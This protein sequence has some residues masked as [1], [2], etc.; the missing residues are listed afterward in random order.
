MKK[1]TIG[2]LLFFSLISIVSAQDTR[3]VVL[4][5]VTGTW[6]GY[7][8]CGHE[9]I[10]NDILEDYP[11]TIIL[12]YHGGRNDPLQ[13]F[14]GNA[15][16]GLMGFVSYPSGIIDRTSSPQSRGVWYS[17]VMNQQNVA[18]AV[19]IETQR[20]YNETTRN[21]YTVVKVTAL[22]DLNGSYSV[23]LVLTED[24]LV[25]TQTSYSGCPAAGAGY[26]HNHVVR[27]ML[28]GERGETFSSGSWAT[29]SAKSYEFATTIDEEFIDENC[30]L[31]VM[32]YKENSN[33]PYANIQQAEEYDLLG[34]EDFNVVVNEG[35]NLVSVP[36][37]LSDMAVTSVFP[38][39]TSSAYE[40]SN[41]YY[42]VNNF[43]KGKGYWLKFG[44]LGTH[45]M[46]GTGFTGSV[47][48]NEGWNLI[49]VYDKSVDADQ[50]TTEPAGIIS[51]VFYGF[52]N[53]YDVAENL[54]TGKGYWVKASQNGSLSFD[55]NAA[56]SS[57]AKFYESLPG[58]L[59]K[60]ANNKTQ[61]LYF[62]VSS[63]D[64]AKADMPPLPPQ[65]L[66]DVRFSSDKFVEEANIVAG[67]ELQ[68]VSFPVTLIT[69]GIDLT[70]TDNSGN[71]YTLERNTEV[72]ISKE[73]TSF[74]VNTMLTPESFVLHQNYPNPFNP[75]T[76]ISFELPFQANIELAVYNTLGEKI[77][78]LADGS[79][80]SGSHE[81]TF[82][83]SDVA[84]G[85]YF[86]KLS[87]DGFVK[88]NKMILLK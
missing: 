18:P 38:N 39:A 67:I 34:G 22:E 37:E 79:Y 33:L 4:E 46:S 88:T 13:Y 25:A 81:V 83:A 43:E 66:F 11:K 10:Q 68:G 86:Y 28:N 5:Y 69:S 24:D 49:G 32:V 84:S 47:T 6:C 56:K 3:N 1:V 70:L 85:I 73:S 27:S 19:R 54:K 14:Y 20:S 41:G 57:D 44:E 51:S 42:T 17:R 12:G 30:H 65:G 61:K 59:V 9:I 45:N 62:S 15:I 71:N 50:V 31:V 55:A 48:L 74:T 87:S 21:L 36:Y 26:V 75:E 2:V 72:T 52:S 58:I 16:R 8:P 23:S 60:D 29:G 76:K 78:V 53:S 64:V 35:W 40:F 7:C 80:E 77:A 82:N 63:N